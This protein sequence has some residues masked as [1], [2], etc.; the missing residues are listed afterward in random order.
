MIGSII[1]FFISVKKPLL[2]KVYEYCL[3]LYLYMMVLETKHIMLKMGIVGFVF[4]Y[5][6]LKIKDIDI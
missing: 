5:F 6:E 4:V 2:G 3:K 1:V